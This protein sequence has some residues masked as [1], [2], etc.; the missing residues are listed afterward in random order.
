MQIGSPAAHALLV[1]DLLNPTLSEAQSGPRS[2]L[3]PSPSPATRFLSSSS[4]DSHQCTN[5]S[6]PPRLLTS[7]AQ[8]LVRLGFHPNFGVD[9]NRNS[10][11]REGTKSIDAS[12]FRARFRP[13]PLL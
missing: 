3:V 2:A 13:P 8:S 11:G 6:S 9:S 10:I 7:T 4:Q 1:N 5:P 12:S